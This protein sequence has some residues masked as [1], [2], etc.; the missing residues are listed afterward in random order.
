[1]DRF[2]EV[3]LYICVITIILDIPMWLLLSDNHIGFSRLIERMVILFIYSC[4][5]NPY[6]HFHEL[7]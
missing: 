1:M 6:N 4:S 2:I 5:Q 3:K 7:E